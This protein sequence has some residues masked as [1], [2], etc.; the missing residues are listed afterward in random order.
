MFS[1]SDAKGTAL[2][3]GGA[4]RIGRAI[5]LSLAERGYGIALHYRSSEAE[6]KDL[7]EEISRKGVECG[8]FLKCI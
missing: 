2:V 3:T 7:A 5:A 6:A 1:E 4:K 8:L